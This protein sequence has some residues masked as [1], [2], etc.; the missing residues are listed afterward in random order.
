MSVCKAQ[1]CSECREKQGKMTGRRSQ[2]PRVKY[3][4]SCSQLVRNLQSAV[5]KRN[6]RATVG[7]RTYQEEYST[8]VDKEEE[9]KYHRE[10]LKKWRAKRH[11]TML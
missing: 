2:N 10:Y 9:R 11:S 6:R 5:W 4:Q 1:L 8:Y 3:C 7:W